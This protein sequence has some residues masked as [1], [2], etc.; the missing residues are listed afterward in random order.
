MTLTASVGNQE[1]T[2]GPGQCLTVGRNNASRSH[3]HAGDEDSLSRVA[4]TICHFGDYW[5]VCGAER[6]DGHKVLVRHG[7]ES[8]Q[9]AASIPQ[10]LA[11]ERASLELPC[12]TATKLD[13]TSVLVRANLNLP[14]WAGSAPGSFLPEPRDVVADANMVTDPLLRRTW[15]TLDDAPRW[16]VYA[17]ARAVPV[18]HPDA[19]SAT[20]WTASRAKAA[21]NAWLRIDGNGQWGRSSVEAANV[22]GRET[23]EI[24]A[25]AV[26]RG[27]VTRQDVETLL[28]RY[29]HHSLNRRPGK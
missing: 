11:W 27:F 18:L 12:G 10:P 23:P 14:R 24:P 7:G 13:H 21:F 26:R 6:S 20:E 3:L 2:I 9:I 15:A 8:I 19:W 25:E 17:T 16:A 29:A 4:A 22:L 1:A 5:S 28:Q